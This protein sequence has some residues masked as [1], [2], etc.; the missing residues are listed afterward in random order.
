MSE[1]NADLVELSRAERGA[2]LYAPIEAGQYARVVDH[3]TPAS[4]AEAAAIEAFLAT[5][6]ECCETWEDKPAMAQSTALVRLDSHVETL[7][8]HGLRVYAA[9]VERTI[10]DAA[11]QAHRLPVAL[12][13]VARAERGPVTVGLP[14]VLAVES[15]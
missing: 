14:E 10:K 2:D 7:A 5:Y 1:P 13:K 4:D 12:V 11:G 8:E 3:E 6:L 15:S 9:T